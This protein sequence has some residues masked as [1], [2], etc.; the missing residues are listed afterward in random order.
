MADFGLASGFAFASD[1][2]RTLG[3]TLAVLTFLL[4]PVLALVA[5]V[6]VGGLFLRRRHGSAREPG[7]RP[8]SDRAGQRGGMGCLVLFFLVFLL[9]G[10]GFFYGFF[11]RP[12]LGIMAAR[13]WLE[14]PCTVLSS[15]VKSHRGDDGTT[16]SIGMVYTYEFAG[17][18]H[19]SSRYDFM[20]GSSS[21]Y[22]GKRAVVDRLPPGTRTMCYVN[23]D[24]PADA[25]LERGYTPDLWFGLIPLVFVAVGLGGTVYSLRRWRR[26]ADAAS[27]T[28]GLP[29]TA[30]TLVKDGTRE[31]T[32]APGE[33]ETVEL[34]PKLAPWMRLVG[35]TILALFWNGIVSVFLLQLLQ[36]WR[37]GR[38][39]WFLTLF[40]IPFVVVGLGLIVAA[41]YFL[42]AL[43]N[44]R[45]RVLVTP[46]AVRLGGRLQVEWRFTGRS[47]VLQQVRVWL[48]GRE[49]ATY[50]RGTQTSTDRSCFARLD[51]ARVSARGELRTGTG[52]TALPIGTM[53]SF[54][55]A[56]NKI[57]WSLRVKGEIEFWPDVDDEYPITVLPAPNPNRANP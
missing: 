50:R 45:A 14:V 15:E 42:L 27:V 8:I 52:T 11:V 12:V 31:A 46:G 36:G 18:E 10:G 19:Q 22:A 20:G 56:N 23:P 9:M 25:V 38:S 16:Y 2:A 13:D 6:G 30:P 39:D 51:L 4:M 3:A 21:G 47:D 48:E 55:S 44:P 24:D 37:S 5:A 29:T 28:T 43:F 34:K 1:V 32:A 54:A 35:T 7:N 41:G 49:E 40:M 26:P 57:V 33:G 17:R 53:H